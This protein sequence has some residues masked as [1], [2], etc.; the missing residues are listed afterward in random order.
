MSENDFKLMSGMGTLITAELFYF[1]SLDWR[2]E[3]EL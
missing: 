1:G 3:E 2:A